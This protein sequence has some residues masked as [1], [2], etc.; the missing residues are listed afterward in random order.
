MLKKAFLHI[1][2]KYNYLTYMGAWGELMGIYM[3]A[4]YNFMG[5]ISNIIGLVCW[6]TYSIKTKSAPGLIIVSIAGIVMNLIGVY[7][8]L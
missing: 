8:W 6:L 7:K 1:F 4:E 5:F 2:T 3:I